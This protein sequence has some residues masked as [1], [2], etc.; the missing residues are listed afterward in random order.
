M[1]HTL[2]DVVGTPSIWTR[3]CLPLNELDKVVRLF[4]AQA[5]ESFTVPGEQG[6]LLWEICGS[7]IDSGRVEIRTL[8][9]RCCWR[10]L[11]G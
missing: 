4:A 1:L 7:R 8:V 3:L 5:P 10:V 9:A 11:M 6:W 2:L